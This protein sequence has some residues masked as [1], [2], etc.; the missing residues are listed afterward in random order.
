MEE[1]KEETKPDRTDSKSIHINFVDLN[2]ISPIAP[3]FTLEDIASMAAIV[4]RCPA[5]DFISRYK[6][7]CLNSENNEVQIF[8]S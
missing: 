2:I 4:L 7:Y 1:S 3:P 8:R 6:I 5:E